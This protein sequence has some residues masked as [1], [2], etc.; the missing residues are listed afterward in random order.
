MDY[1]SFFPS[2]SAD[3]L[4][5]EDAIE[6]K[7]GFDNTCD[8][9]EPEL[10]ISTERSLYQQNLAL[11]SDLDAQFSIG[12]AGSAYGDSLDDLLRDN[13]SS[14]TFSASLDTPPELWSQ[15]SATSTY[16]QH[17]TSMGQE[18]NLSSYPEG[19]FLGA[20]T[21]NIA[22]DV[23]ANTCLPSLDDTLLWLLASNP[24]EPFLSNCDSNMIA[25]Y[26]PVPTTAATVEQPRD[27][28]VERLETG[29]TTS[30]SSQQ[31]PDSAPLIS[32]TPAQSTRSGAL[33]TYNF[34]C[35]WEGCGTSIQCEGL[36]PA[37]HDTFKL[38]IRE[39]VRQHARDKVAAVDA[40]HNDVRN[41]HPAKAAAHPVAG[42]MCHW[43]GCAKRHELKTVH[44]LTRH[45]LTHTKLS[46]KCSDCQASYGVF[47]RYR[48]TKFYNHT[49][50]VL[51][52]K[53]IKGRC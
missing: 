40:Q 8:Y 25:Q 38:A 21:S 18:N 13:G 36:S 53:F 27:A 49:C 35:L 2:N 37:H 33:S 34:T 16:S 1:S 43:M 52:L 26:F 31:A 7:T 14:D 15:S 51:K 39:H 50:K 41:T 47:S 24:A 48:G 23:S 19:Q 10:C 4:S 22:M 9:S 6:F 46:M 30:I 32:T 11:E 44:A 3:L 45:L 12:D 42:R 28:S 29:L 17:S 20:E 5:F